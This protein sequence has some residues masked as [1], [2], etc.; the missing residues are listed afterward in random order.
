M[1][2]YS[3]L[4]LSILSLMGSSH[5]QAQ[6][7]L[8][9]TG[10]VT[11]SYSY[12]EFQYLPEIADDTDGLPVLLDIVV[13]VTDTISLTGGYQLAAASA[14][15]AAGDV[16]AAVQVQSLTVGVSYH[17]ELTALANSDWVAELSLGRN[18]VKASRN[19]RGDVT[20]AQ[21][22]SNFQFAYAGIRR[23]FTDKLEGEVGITVERNEVDT[24][25]TGEIRA[26]YRL[27]DPIDIAVAFNDIGETDLFG[28]GLRYTW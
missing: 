4:I 5:L 25:V 18:E 19:E 14:S 24:E 23:S 20:S 28:I 26:V 16:T 6:D 7:L 21:G 22:S 1:S 12:V 8:G 11:R 2:R 9:S 13:A 27:M 3:T 17:Q 10:S 15:N